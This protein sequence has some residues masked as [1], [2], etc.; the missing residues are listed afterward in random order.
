MPYDLGLPQF[1]HPI[2][3]FGESLLFQEACLFATVSLSCCL[4]AQGGNGDWLREEE[5]DFAVFVSVFL[6]A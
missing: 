3:L 1:V 6:T 2:S 4:G 5:E